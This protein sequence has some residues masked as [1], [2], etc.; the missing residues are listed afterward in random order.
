MGFWELGGLKPIA[1]I[2]VAYGTYYITSLFDCMV[3]YGGWPETY[4]YL[5]AECMFF[6]IYILLH[7]VA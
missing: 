5:V 6:F 7:G 1:T 3:W 2:G 4:C